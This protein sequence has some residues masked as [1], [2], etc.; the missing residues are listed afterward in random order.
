MGNITTER[1]IDGSTATERVPAAS[2]L[3][4]K[5]VFSGRYET[6]EW[7]INYDKDYSGEC[8]W[9]AESKTEWGHVTDLMYSFADAKIFL[10]GTLGIETLISTTP[11]RWDTKYDENHKPYRVAV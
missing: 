6:A 1:W 2:E 7:I 9:I 4:L 10:A 3:N 8:K 11:A 5:R